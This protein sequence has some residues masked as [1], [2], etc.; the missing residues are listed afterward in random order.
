MGLLQESPGE[1]GERQYSLG[2]EEERTERSK[3]QPACRVSSGP[4]LRLLFR[5]LR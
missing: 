5:G 4:E 3:D 1:R 2:P